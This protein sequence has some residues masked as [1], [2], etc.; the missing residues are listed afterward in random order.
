MN[1]ILVTG[2]AGYVGSHACKMLKEAGFNPIVYD[3]LTTGHKKFVRWGP[4][5][6]GDLLDSGLLISTLDKFKP[7][8]V[9]H[10]AASAYVGE[11]VQNPLKYYQNNVGGTLSLLRS[12]ELTAVK[13]IVFSST[14]ATYGNPDLK[15]IK[16]NHDQ[17]PINPYGSSKLMVEKIL[18]DLAFQKKINQI[19]LRYFNAAGAD[20]SGQIGELHNPETHLIPLA[21]NAGLH[22]KTLNVFGT[23]FPTPDGSAVR[24]FVH[25]EDL[26]RAHVLSV[27]YIL[28][29]Q[30]VSEFINLGT[31]SGTSVF[32]V[33]ESL[34]R[35]GLE[36]DIKKCPRRDG[37]PPYL[38]ADSDLAF[39][40]LK[41]SPRYKNIDEILK[42]ALDW[43]KNSKS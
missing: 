14:C 20:S 43:H 33:I 36:I 25:V 32:D 9:M 16:E 5:V 13:N 37:D 34:R 38:V 6:V 19:S 42:T 22:S 31:G 8:A 26:G 1:N 7:C 39:R 24:D 3:N 2:G 35:C 18:N 10:F 15:K 23:D 4:L 28:A 17:N 29:R 11:S 40:L 27:E 21:I 30:S 41:W 12:M